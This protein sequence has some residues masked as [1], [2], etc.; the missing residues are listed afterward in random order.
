MQDIFG[1]LLYLDEVDESRT[2]LP[3]P[4]AL[5]HKILVKVTIDLL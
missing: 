1:D 5:K 2:T 3:S 4:E